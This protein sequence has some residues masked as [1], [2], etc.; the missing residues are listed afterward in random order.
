MD[1]LYIIILCNVLKELCAISDNI[2]TCDIASITDIIANNN[3]YINNNNNN[4]YLKSSIQTSSIDYKKYN[5][6]IKT[7]MIT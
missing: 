7:N 5:D 6:T 3:I 4:I 1:M 2:T